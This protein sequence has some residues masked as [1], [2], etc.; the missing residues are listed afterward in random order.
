[1]TLSQ[2]ETAIGM[3]LDLDRK[4]DDFGTYFKPRNCPD[5]FGILVTPRKQNTVAII[6][7]G[8]APSV[9]GIRKGDSSAKVKELINIYGN[10]FSKLEPREAGSS[11][12]VYVISS[13]YPK[14]KSEYLI[15]FMT[16]NG[17]VVDI[18]AGF[19]VDGPDADDLPPPIFKRQKNGKPN[20]ESM[21][22]G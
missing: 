4:D 20:K 11:D 1:M 7:A 3:P 12:F 2:A 22:G 6:F 5:S 21:R 17:K 16:N 9:D 14:Q 8:T 13:T 19:T 10:R 15:A 18:R